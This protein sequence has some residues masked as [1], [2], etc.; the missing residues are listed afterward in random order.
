M[1]SLSRRHIVCLQR[2]GAAFA[3]H[4]VP[5]LS[6]DVAEPGVHERFKD[7]IS[8]P[9]LDAGMRY[10]HVAAGGNNYTLFLR[11]DGKVI[12]AG[13]PGDGQTDIPPLP[14]GLEYTACAASGEFSALLRSDGTVIVCGNDLD[15]DDVGLV[16]PPLP[17]GV[18]YIQVSCGAYTIV[19]LRSDGTAVACGDNRSGQCEIPELE[20]GVR[21][22]QVAAGQWHTVFLRSDGRVVASGHG[23]PH[24]VDSR[25]PPFLWRYHYSYQGECTIPDLPPGTRYTQVDASDQLT[26]LLRSDGRAVACGVNDCGQCNIPP[27]HSAL[28]YTQV[29][30]GCR[31]TVLLRSDGTLTHSGLV[32]PSRFCPGWWD[33]Q[34]FAMSPIGAISHPEL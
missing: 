33:E 1:L 21:Y 12:A 11:S 25:L 8:I 5:P 10:T 23:E 20:Q 15:D 24:V 30:A 29:C 22:T 3:N 9:P 13:S 34:R 28:H 31:C 17:K 32:D 2:N 16:P 4:L 27:L 7:C 26:V 18:T 6:L 14:K 19:L